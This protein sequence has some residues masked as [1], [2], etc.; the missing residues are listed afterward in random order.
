MKRLKRFYKILALFIAISFISATAN[1]N[2]SYTIGKS[3]I[4]AKNSKKYNVKVLEIRKANGLKSGKLNRGMKLSLTVSEKVRRNKHYSL[5]PKRNI[6]KHSVSEK[7]ETKNNR[8]HTVRKGNTL[9]SATKKYGITVSALKRINN[10][11]RGGLKTDRQLVIR[12]KKHSPEI[13]AAGKEDTINKNA[14][15][16]K[17]GADGSK[18]IKDVKEMLISGDVLGD[19]SI[20]KRLVL[21]AKNMLHEPYHFGGNGTIGL[22]CSCY[23]QRVF[24]FV[25]ENMPRS[26]REQFNLGE[27]VDK[28]YLEEGDL[29]FFKTYASFPS[30]VGIYLG[31]HLFIHASWLSRQ[32]TIDNLET[33]YFCT[34]YIG[35]RRIIADNGSAVLE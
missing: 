2:V 14:N 31:N 26:A 23:V 10:L 28:K 20:R 34:H 21:F 24:G 4:L 18:E 16:F 25:G 30:H 13:Y 29:V 22:D 27:A 32:I 7:S 8:I 11:K 33:P 19:L 5:N 6:S 12:N 1:A 9:K 17:A 35:A 3:D 15:C